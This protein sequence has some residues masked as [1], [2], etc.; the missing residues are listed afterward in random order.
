MPIDYDPML[1]KLI[2]HGPDRTTALS[3]LR[4]ALADYEVA[5]VDTTLP[6]FRALCGDADFAR[7]EFDVQWLDRRL[8]G[9]L[10]GGDLESPDEV[11]LAAA[12]LALAEARES[13]ASDNGAG[14]PSPW[15]LA[16]RR[17]ALR[18]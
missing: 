9:G 1:G 2:V 17:E 14:E 8:A 7:A 11:R 13:S 15:M 10:L 12:A 3:R 4:R 18:D 16:A 5:G 6:L